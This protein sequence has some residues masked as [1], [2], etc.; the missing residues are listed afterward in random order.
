MTIFVYSWQ[1]TTKNSL[2]LYNGTLPKIRANVFGS[3]YEYTTL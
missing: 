1:T 2:I 3:K